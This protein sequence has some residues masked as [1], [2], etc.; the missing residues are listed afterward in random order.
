MVVG[1][2]RDHNS[3]GT[4]VNRAGGSPQANRLNGSTLPTRVMARPRAGHL[5]RV[6]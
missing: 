3:I 4:I 1:Y 5:V 2:L 6:E